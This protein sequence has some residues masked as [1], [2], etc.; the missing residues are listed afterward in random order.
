MILKRVSIVGRCN[1]LW[2][3]EINFIKPFLLRYETN[4]WKIQAQSSADRSTDWLSLLYV[5]PAVR[6]IQADPSVTRFL[7]LIN[8][9]FPVEQLPGAVIDSRS[10]TD[11]I[12]AFSCSLTAAANKENRK[13]IKHGFT[14]IKSHKLLFFSLFLI[15]SFADHFFFFVWC[16]KKWVRSHWFAWQNANFPSLMMIG[17]GSAIAQFKQRVEHTKWVFYYY[18]KYKRAKRHEWM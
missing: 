9:Y 12:C 13:K 8:N 15:T 7:S 17:C 2:Y 3:D 18:R 11:D 14:T 4:D 6:A 5:S 16:K 10:F 1:S